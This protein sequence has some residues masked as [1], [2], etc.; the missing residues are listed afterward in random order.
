MEN[1]KSQNVVTIQIET[2]AGVENLDDILQVDGVD[3]IFIGTS[4]LSLEFGY[5]TP[6]TPEMDPLLA[7]ITSR[8]AQAGKVCGVHIVDWH[9]IEKHIR[10]GVRYFTVSA[11]AVMGASL[12]D[13]TGEFK[14]QVGAKE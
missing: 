9:A 5:E 8:V 7:D 11:M 12:R 2:K 10:L 1:A 6:G 4:D 3:S 13:L 14:H